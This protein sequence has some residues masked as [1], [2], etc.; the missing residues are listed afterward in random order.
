MSFASGTHPEAH[1]A[2]IGAG[3]SRPQTDHGLEA[4]TLAVG[5]ASAPR[6]RREVIRNLEGRMQDS[7]EA[8]AKLSRRLLFRA[9]AGATGAM[10]A[11]RGAPAGWPG[12]DNI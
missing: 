12:D 5:T 9:L 1:P 4:M 11:A 6:D 7:R 2:D 10:T 3:E 8:S